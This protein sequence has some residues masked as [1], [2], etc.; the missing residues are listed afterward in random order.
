MSGRL[1]YREVNRA[2][3]ARQLLLA[4]ESLPPEEAIARLAGLQAQVVTPPFVGLWTRLEAFE[5]EQLNE[6]IA[7]RRV[8]RAHVMRSTLHLF[9]AEDYLRLRADLQP[10]LARAYHGF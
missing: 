1:T 8:V 9:T 3:L 7:E 6:A 2:T 10:A 4:R 5:R